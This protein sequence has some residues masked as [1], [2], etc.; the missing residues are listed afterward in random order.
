MD[1]EMVN[2]ADDKEPPKLIRTSQ[3]R[4]IYPPA[5]DS[6]R[7]T[8][9]FNNGDVDRLTTERAKKV[10]ARFGQELAQS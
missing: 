10:L 5:A 9:V 3:I 6:T 1:N 2:L 8:V 7:W 4:S